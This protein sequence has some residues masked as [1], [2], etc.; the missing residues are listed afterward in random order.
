MYGCP[1]IKSTNVYPHPKYSKRIRKP[2]SQPE[3][4]QPSYISIY[5]IRSPNKK[6]ASHALSCISD[7]FKFK[8]KTHTQKTP[9]QHT[10]HPIRDHHHVHH[11]HQPPPHHQHNIKIAACTFASAPSTRRIRIYTCI[12]NLLQMQTLS[13]YKMSKNS[14]TLQ[15]HEFSH[16]TAKLNVTHTA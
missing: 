15:S 1:T 16:C 8:K 9:W 6:R 13:L 2:A 3:G 10:Y 7:V 4:Y 14:H 12:F 11:H 5:E